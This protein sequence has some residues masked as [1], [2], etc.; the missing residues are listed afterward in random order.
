MTFGITARHVGRSYLD[1][2]NNGSFIAPAFTTFEANGAIAIGHDMSLRIQIN[3][4]LNNKRVF[5]SGYS[6][7]F[8]TPQ[9]TIEG[10]SYYY[11]QATRNA[12]VMVDFRR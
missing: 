1:N 12:S 5:P 3:N 4:L 9:R 2:T 11:P 7:L 6:Y 10:V 8:L